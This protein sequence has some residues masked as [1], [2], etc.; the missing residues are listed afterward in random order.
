MFGDDMIPTKKTPKAGAFDVRTPHAFRFRDRET[1][2]IETGLII[3]CPKGYDYRL[4]IRSSLAAKGIIMTTGVGLIDEDYCGQDD[5]LHL[6][7][8]NLSGFEQ[9]FDALERVAQINFV[10]K[11]EEIQLVKTSINHFRKNETRGGLGSTGRS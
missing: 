6:I 9:E 10:E 3:E 1:I 2:T 4:R 11:P 5:Q 8:H 7:F